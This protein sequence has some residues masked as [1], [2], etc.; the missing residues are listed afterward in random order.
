MAGGPFERFS[1]IA[2]GLRE[3]VAIK[4]GSQQCDV[5]VW[6]ELTLL[7]S[8]KHPFRENVDFDGSFAPVPDLVDAELPVDFQFVDAASCPL[9]FDR[10]LWAFPRLRPKR[11]ALAGFGG[12]FVLFSRQRPSVKQPHFDA[13]IHAPRCEDVAQLCLDLLIILL[14][15]HD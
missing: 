13:T 7:R 1:E 15:A 4:Y 2:H 14:L 8:G 5:E 10:E 11:I 9:D 3:G 6:E 12:T